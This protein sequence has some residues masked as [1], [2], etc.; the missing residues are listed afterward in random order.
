MSKKTKSVKV[1]EELPK[2]KSSKKSTGRPKSIKKEKE[3]VAD[4]QNTNENEENKISLVYGS[5]LTKQV[6]PFPASDLQLQTKNL[7]KE[8]GINVSLLAQNIV[9]AVN[10]LVQDFSNFVSNPNQF[11]LIGGIMDKDLVAANLIKDWLSD[12]KTLLLEM[13]SQKEDEKEEVVVLPAVTS[14]TQITTSNPSASPH[15]NTGE[16]HLDN[17]FTPRP[18][19]STY[20]HT[21]NNPS[22]ENKDIH[23]QVLSDAYPSIIAQNTA[24]QNWG[25]NSIVEQKPLDMDKIF[26]DF[27]KSIYDSIMESFQMRFWGFIPEVEVRGIINRSDSL[28]KYELV[29]NGENSFL[30][31]KYGDK[32]HNTKNFSV[33]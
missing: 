25:S 28:Y 11:N 2:S 21:I 17:K 24:Q 32:I 14:G 20:Q 12:K 29:L 23:Y 9:D 13:K 27:C 1:K 33:K 18:P 4:I 6:I 7:I 22:T 10:S 19:V 5:E 8:Y 3:I 15:F 30:S 31:I 16:N 26:E